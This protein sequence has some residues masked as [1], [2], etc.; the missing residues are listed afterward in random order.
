M[1]EFYEKARWGVTSVRVAPGTIKDN[2]NENGR[3]AENVFPIFAE[4]FKPWQKLAK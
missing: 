4:T 2:R 3:E 1:K